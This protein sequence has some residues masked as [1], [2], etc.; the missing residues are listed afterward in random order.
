MGIN[1]CC[2]IYY[3]RVGILIDL[4]VGLMGWILYICS[5]DFIESKLSVY[6]YMLILFFFCFIKIFNN[7]MIM[8]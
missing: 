5:I 8:C 2:I 3:S 6:K 4:V 1:Y 7:D